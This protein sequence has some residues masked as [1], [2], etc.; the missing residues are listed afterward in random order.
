[1]SLKWLL[2]PHRPSRPPPPFPLDQSCAGAIFFEN[3]NGVVLGANFLK[4]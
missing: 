1:V 4:V 3:S 2:P